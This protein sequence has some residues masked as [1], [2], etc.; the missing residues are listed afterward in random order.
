MSRL[1]CSMNATDFELDWTYG[2]NCSNNT[3]SA[4][5]NS[6]GFPDLVPSNYSNET[7]FKRNE[8]RNW[9]SSCNSWPT[10]SSSFLDLTI[11]NC[12]NKTY[13]EWNGTFDWN[14][15]YNVAEFPG[16]KLLLFIISLTAFAIP[17]NITCLYVLI[18]FKGT[19]YSKSFICLI[20]V[21]LSLLVY[22]VASL[23]SAILQYREYYALNTFAARPY[24]DAITSWSSLC[25]Y[26][27]VIIFT[28]D[29]AFAV[30]R[31]LKHKVIRVRKLILEII[32][33]TIIEFLLLIPYLVLIKAESY[34]TM[35]NSAQ[36]SLDILSLF[37]LL[38]ILGLTGYKLRKKRLFFPTI[39][40]SKKQSR[41]ITLAIIILVSSVMFDII[42]GIMVFVHFHKGDKPFWMLIIEVAPQINLVIYPLT[43][44]FGIANIRKSLKN[45]VYNLLCAV[46]Q[47]FLKKPDQSVDQI[48]TETI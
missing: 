35:V 3:W 9:N 41:I 26:F 29:I 47:L 21:C 27:A 31:P 46:K 12:S 5:S 6:T 22:A 30:L 44:V 4:N 25:C 2:W 36:F 15:S 28:L 40:T 43:L 1:N 11:L 24:V 34:T 37:L 42:P 33:C 8:I 17:L 38:V 45:R 7:K 23:T 20:N 16:L 32:I 13:A 39:D 18:I 19:E 10:N 48:E 14:S